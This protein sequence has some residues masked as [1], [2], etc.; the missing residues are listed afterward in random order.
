MSDAIKEMDNAISFGDFR[1]VS[2]FT[3]N[4]FPPVQ[5]GDVALSPTVSLLVRFK[6]DVDLINLVMECISFWCGCTTVIIKNI[7]I[8]EM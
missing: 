7:F 3:L 1:S 5:D 2:D 8:F 4:G 6:L